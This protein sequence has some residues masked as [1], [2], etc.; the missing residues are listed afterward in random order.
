ME[1]KDKWIIP[2]KFEPVFNIIL[3]LILFFILGVFGLFIFYASSR[4]FAFFILAIVF[5]IT[6]KEPGRGLYVLIFI[7]PLFLYFPN[8]LIEYH[9]PIIDIVLFMILLNW[10]LNILRKNQ[11]EFKRTPIDIYFIIFIGLSCISVI[12]LIPSIF[13]N[14]ISFPPY[15]RIIQ[16]YFIFTKGSEH[17]FN[18]VKVFIYIIEY[19]LLFFFI[20]NNLK[21]EQIKKFFITIAIATFLV[22]IYGIYQ[23]F[24]DKINL[25]DYFL[26]FNLSIGWAGRIH[27]TF[28]HPN[29][30]GMFLGFGD[31]PPDK[32]LITFF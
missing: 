18:V 6:F 17:I 26:R 22:S 10:I 29:P 19:F 9:I 2:K 8:L 5:L 28:V 3:Y 14:F 31:L 20:T 27:S 15:E 11:L 24:F 21:K 16:F 30:F 13:S 1:L 4:I 25:F 23:Y 7:L 32:L 12:Q